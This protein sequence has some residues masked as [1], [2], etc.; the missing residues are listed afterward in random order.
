MKTFSRRDALRSTGALVVSFA[1]TPS[2]LFGQAVATL[3]GNP[4]KDLD[5][6]LSIDAGGTVTAL[7][8]KC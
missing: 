5:G 2:D 8:G 1:L 3:V 4:P 7:T 6:W